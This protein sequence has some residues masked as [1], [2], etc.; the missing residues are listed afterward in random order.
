MSVVAWK[1]PAD[2]ERKL[3][4]CTGDHVT[5]YG[6]GVGSGVGAAVGAI[7]TGAGA[8]VPG[9]M[10]GAQTYAPTA[11]KPAQARRTITTPRIVFVSI[12]IDWGNVILSPHNHSGNEDPA[13]CP[14]HRPGRNDRRGTCRY[15]L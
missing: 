13:F 1:N 7:V 6:V 3:I 4:R 15:V 10:A 9:C 2:V 14:G 5:G 8:T 12:V 11:I